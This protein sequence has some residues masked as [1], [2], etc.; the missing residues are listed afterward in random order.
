MYNEKERVVDDWYIIPGFS[1]YDIGYNTKYIR[2]HKH[3]KRDSHHIMKQSKRPINENPS[4]L[5]TDDAGVSR[6]IKRQFL[7]DKT[8]NMGYPLE[9]RNQNDVYLGGMKKYNRYM[10]G[11]VQLLKG[12]NYVD[13]NDRYG[14]NTIEPNFH[15]YNPIIPTTNEYYTPNFGAVTDERGFIIPFTV[16]CDKNK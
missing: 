3:F 8:F 2:S 7:Y 6:H 15:I 13:E 12:V 16:N 11:D 14:Y 5:L 9:K 4:V 1:S 10:K